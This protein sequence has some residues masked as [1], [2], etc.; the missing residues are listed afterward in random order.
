[1]CCLPL[2]ALTAYPEHGDVM[3]FG[4]D[5]LGLGSNDYHD[6]RTRLE[7]VRHVTLMTQMYHLA[8]HRAERGLSL[9]AA[10]LAGVRLAALHSLQN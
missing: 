1:M 3:G 7:A 5:F 2:R 6:V 9:S 4:V 8:K 10:S